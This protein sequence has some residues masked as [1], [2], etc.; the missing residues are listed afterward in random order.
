ML[1]TALQSGNPIVMA[2]PVGQWTPGQPASEHVRVVGLRPE[3]GMYNIHHWNVTVSR[4]D[5][6]RLELY[7][8]TD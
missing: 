1:L 3:S 6:S 4:R 8:K 5:G 7:V 2:L